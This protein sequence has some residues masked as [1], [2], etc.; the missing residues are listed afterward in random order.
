MVDI[1][2]KNRK[3]FWVFW[4]RDSEE[5]FW[6]KMGSSDLIFIFLWSGCSRGWT[7]SEK[8]CIFVILIGNLVGHY[9]TTKSACARVPY[10]WVSVY[11]VHNNFILLFITW[12]IVFSWTSHI[13]LCIQT[14]KIWLNSSMNKEIF[15]WFL[16]DIE[17]KLPRVVTRTQLDQSQG[18]SRVG[19][20]K[21]S[22]HSVPHKS[23]LRYYFQSSPSPRVQ[24]S[25]AAATGVA[26]PGSLGGGVGAPS[27]FGRIQSKILF[28]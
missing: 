12:Y 2:V 11:S 24:R 1:C 13:L 17:R 18:Q 27:D 20:P 14:W 6:A 7:S 9:K 26:E 19:N 21:P 10:T 5:K 28:H 4:G 22:K 15:W 23:T 25:L 8:S 16:G 3:L